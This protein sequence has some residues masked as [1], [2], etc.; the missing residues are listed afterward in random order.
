MFGRAFAAAFEVSGVDV[1]GVMSGGVSGSS[2]LSNT[3]PGVR[4]EWEVAS[5]G[6]RRWRG[7]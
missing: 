6:C 1:A 5:R 3:A 2:S 7:S 4:V